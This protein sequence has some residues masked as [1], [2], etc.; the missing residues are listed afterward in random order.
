MRGT[1]TCNYITK[2]SSVKRCESKTLYY[3]S[4]D[5]DTSPLVTFMT[6]KNPRV[7]AGLIY[8]SPSWPKGL[9]IRPFRDDL[10]RKE[11]SG[12]SRRDHTKVRSAT[13]TDVR[14]QRHWGHSRMHQ[15]EGSQGFRP[16]VQNYTQDY[17][18]R[19]DKRPSEHQY[20]HYDYSH[21]TQGP[22]A[23]R[24]SADR[25]WQDNTRSDS[26]HTGGSHRGYTSYTT[27]GHQGG[28]TGE[29]ARWRQSNYYERDEDWQRYE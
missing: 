6:I 9:I 7:L 25:P 20:H 26:R 8:T 10:P 21:R 11:S 3:R 1:V 27:G 5:S 4:T 18:L 19:Y 12:N 24:A 13:E 15:R 29:S 14:Q 28:R 23:F 2:K 16:Q 17:S 22:P